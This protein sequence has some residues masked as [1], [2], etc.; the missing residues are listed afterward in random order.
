MIESAQVLM[1][2]AYILFFFGVLPNAHQVWKNRNHLRGFS[3][4]GISSVTV[5]LIFTQT[6][7]FLDKAFFPVVIGMPNLIYYIGLTYLL[8][9]KEPR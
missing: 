2:V 7:L 1:G 9:K 4:F 5:G 6:A 3:R 8:W